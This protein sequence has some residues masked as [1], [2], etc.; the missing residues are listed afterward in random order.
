M[1]ATDSPS[2]SVPK[3]AAWMG[4]WLVLM[5]AMAVA[6]RETAS[7]IDALQ[8]M[9]LRSSIGFVLLLP[10]VV[11]AGG[12]RAMRT[13][14]PWRHLGRNAV[15]YAAQYLWL[16]AVTLI[17]LAQVISIEFTMPIWT[18]ILAVAFLGER[19]HAGKVWAI[20]LGSLGVWIIVR[21]S[22][23]AIEPGQLLALA[24]AVGFAVSVILVKTLTRTESVTRIIFWM[25]VVQSAIG[26]LPALLVWR[27]IPDGLW[28]WLL[29]VA[30]CGTFSHF[31]M[32]RAMRHVDATV[33]VPMDFLR[34]PLTALA[35]WLF[36][37]ERIDLLTALGATLVL[38]ANL[39]N[40]RRSA[41]A[42]AAAAERCGCSARG[43]AGRARRPSPPR[44]RA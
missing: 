43:T 20:A 39:L 9:L 7:R 4:G 33:V 25:L 22:A 40:L 32:A 1:I 8:V 44:A 23:G 36:Y 21:P 35:G 28:P 38:A 16:V 14:R 10:L 11:A 41:P 12:P 29:L 31:C 26:L 13:A 19:M 3:A 42:P 15:H 34:V 30:F 2:S 5:V 24:A 6:G 18:A 27:P 17:P 37:A